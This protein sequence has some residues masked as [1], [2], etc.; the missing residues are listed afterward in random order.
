MDVE[1]KYLL[2]NE[3]L[4]ISISNFHGWFKKNYGNFIYGNLK[5]SDIGYSL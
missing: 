2:I 5:L 1:T 4:I 3:D